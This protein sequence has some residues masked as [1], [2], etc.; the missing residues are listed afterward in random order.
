[1][2]D[3]RNNKVLT[4]NR[5]LSNILYGKLN[6]VDSNNINNINNLNNDKS[7]LKTNNNN[8]FTSPLQSIPNGSYRKSKY[9]P[10]KHRLRT[11]TSITDNNRLT[12][13]T[14]N[15]SRIKNAL[16]EGTTLTYHQ[17][18]EN[19]FYYAGKGLSMEAINIIND[20][21]DTNCT[22]NIK[23]CN[24]LIKELGDQ[25][26]LEQCEELISVLKYHKVPLSI[27]T[28]STLISRAGTWKKIH[29]AEK[30]FNQMLQDGII[31][32]VPAYNSL[33]NAYAKVDNIHKALEVLNDM[34]KAQLF[35]SIITFNTLIDACSRDGNVINAQAVF[36]L[37]KQRNYQPNAR[38]YSA[39]I[40]TYCQARQLTTAFKLMHEMV[41]VE[42]LKPNAV[43]YTVRV[44]LVLLL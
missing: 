29:L 17:K 11:T 26:C 36:S 1:M 5:L 7:N 12:N 34:V 43:T 9:N 24:V 22:I 33:M 10:T 20:L 30:Y 40:H 23:D 35:P 6:Y 14:N 31:P 27:V 19:A 38:T 39:L 3:V 25:G 44:L 18:I 32:D 2:Y 13:S 28:Y 37:M 15:Y 16:H 8:I 4:R 21:L 42:K 41:N